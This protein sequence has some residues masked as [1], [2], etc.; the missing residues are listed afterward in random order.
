MASDRPYGTESRRPIVVRNGLATRQWE[1]YLNADGLAGGAAAW[2][3]PNLIGYR[4]WTERL[5]AA[6][7]STRP[8]ALSELQTET[9]WRRIIA[10]SADGRDLISDRGAAEWCARAWEIACHWRVDLDSLS[11]T[12]APHDVRA[13]LRWSGDYRA[14]LAGHG[15]VDAPAIE[16]D[17]ADGPDLGAADVVLADLSDL[18]PVRA[19]LLRRLE[20]EG[21]RIETWSVPE[22]A[23]T[24]RRAALPDGATELRAAVAWAANRLE[25]DPALRIGLI[26]PGLRQRDQEVDR[27]L[28]EKA[29]ASRAPFAIWHPSA[30]LGR[31]GLIGAALTGLELVS[32]GATFATLSRWLRSPLFGA[33]DPASLGERAGLELQLRGQ[34]RAQLGFLDAY[35]RAGLAAWLEAHAPTLAR[36]VAA[37]LEALGS[38]APTTPGRWARRWQRALARLGWPPADH[39]PDDPA[40]VSW[41]SAIDAF[42][43]LT[44]I[45][46]AIDAA[47]ALREL[48][49]IVR[50]RSSAGP[51]PPTGLHVLAHP[52]DIGPGYHAVWATGLTDAQLAGAAA[53]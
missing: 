49:R 28:A 21:G 24:V 17:L 46:G 11:R 23:R 7:D 22:V 41:Q 14:V 13:F 25:R 6:Q 16:R 33:T 35:R 30:S 5:W 43:K 44:P 2:L 31:R 38:A 48:E 37:A 26:V 15:W 4:A 3:T 20:A 10:A 42:A 40:L 12:G 18:A 1:A 8:R 51:L 27:V 52:D 53:A 50:H 45:L 29:A 39:P 47:E 34:V 19:A 32:P 36:G 9:L